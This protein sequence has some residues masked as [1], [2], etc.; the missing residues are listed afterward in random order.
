MWEKI[1]N[2]LLAIALAFWVTLEPIHTILYVVFALVLGDLITGIW[3]SV[4]LKQPFTSNR[5]RDTPVKLVPYLIVILAGFGLDH[6]VGL[7]GLFFTRAFSV[8]IAGTEVISI[9]ENMRDITGLDF[10]AIIREKLKP[11][12]K[13]P[14]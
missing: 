10:A 2:Y 11:P 6:V 8:L 7:E 12:A 1:R 13:P 3:K 4:R 5:L 14:E 9:T